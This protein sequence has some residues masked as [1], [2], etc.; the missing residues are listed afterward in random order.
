MSSARTDPVSWQMS[1]STIVRKAT[2]EGSQVTFDEPSLHKVKQGELMSFHAHVTV[3]QLPQGRHLKRATVFSNVPS[4]GTWE[5]IC[6]EGIAVGGRGSAPSP[7]MYFAAGLA[8]CLMSHV[9]MVAAQAGLRLN[10]VRL[11]QRARFSTTLNLGGIDP[12]KIFGYGDGVEMHLL[13][14]SDEPEEKLT[15]F[16]HHCRQACMS[17]QAVAGTTPVVTELHVNGT[18]H[19]VG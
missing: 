13:V 11:E 7:I 12:A 4:G 19:P 17:L 10:S 5:L 3:D 9:E 16:L 8:L 1:E 2:T 6:D 15:E 18:A 14:D